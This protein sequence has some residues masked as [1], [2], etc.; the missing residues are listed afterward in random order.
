MSDTY[1]LGLIGSPELE[2]GSREHMALARFFMLGSL[3]GAWFMGIDQ[4][5]CKRFGCDPNQKFLLSY[6]RVLYEQ[7]VLSCGRVGTGIVYRHGTL[8]YEEVD[9]IARTVHVFY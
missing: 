1:T 4:A 2:T 9:T 8:P 7:G 3:F 6:S 5:L